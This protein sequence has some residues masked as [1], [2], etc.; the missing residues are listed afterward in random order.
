MLI[1]VVR[2]CILDGS[3][4]SEHAFHRSNIHSQKTS[5]YP[6][7]PVADEQAEKSFRHI[8]LWR[9]WK[10]RSVFEVRK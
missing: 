7:A 10:E 1:K 3:E 6:E 2:E 4:K 5:Q 8:R 9:S